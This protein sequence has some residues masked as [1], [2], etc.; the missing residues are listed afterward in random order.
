MDVAIT[1]TIKRQVYGTKLGVKDN[2]LSA[3]ETLVLVLNDLLR[4]L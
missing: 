3:R 4:A 2:L 1:D